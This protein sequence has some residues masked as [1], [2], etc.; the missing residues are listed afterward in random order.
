MAQQDTDRNGVGWLAALATMAPLLAV[1][2][3]KKGIPLNPEQI[4]TVLQDIR[5]AMG[6]LLRG[7]A[8]AKKPDPKII[9]QL[10]SLG[11]RASEAFPT[12]NPFDPTRGAYQM[13]VPYPRLPRRMGI[14]RLGDLV[15]QPEQPDIVPTLPA[16]FGNQPAVSLKSEWWDPILTTREHDPLGWNEFLGKLFEATQRGT[17]P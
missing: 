17:W 7:A 1:A 10:E 6:M 5:G 11:Q 8:P 13:A 16:R 14:Q 4:N 15:V 2:R 9:R 12:T 3:S